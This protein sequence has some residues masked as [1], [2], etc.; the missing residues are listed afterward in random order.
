MEYQIKDVKTTNHN[1]DSRLKLETY[2]AR[3]S[4][5][6][7]WIKLTGLII[8]DETY[9]YTYFGDSISSIKF[10]K[11]EIAFIVKSED[12][13]DAYQFSGVS[14]LYSPCESLLT[15]IKNELGIFPKGLKITLEIK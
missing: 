9:T 4:K 2:L 5:K 14:N 6:D 11:N 8:G 10:R 3:F 13:E 1:V 12:L 7:K 15:L